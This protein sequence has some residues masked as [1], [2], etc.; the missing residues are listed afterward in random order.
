MVKNR[1]PI[2]VAILSLVTLGLYYLYWFYSTRT[3]I[4]E[5]NKTND[6]PI[7]WTILLFVPIV[8]FYV[9]WKHYGD[10]SKATKGSANAVMLFVLN[11][12][13]FPVALYMAQVE[14]N[15]FAK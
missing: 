11:L 13:L 4:N 1:N 9:M 8:N 5:L 15:K 6:S 12:I 10:L 2:F 7:L 3:E 14:L